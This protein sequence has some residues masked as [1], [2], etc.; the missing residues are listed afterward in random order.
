MIRTDGL[1]RMTARLVARRHALRKTI[2]EELEALGDNAQSNAGGDKLD[3]ALET[4][5]GEVRFQLLELEI[6]ELRKIEHVLRRLAEGSYGRCAR[7]GRKI[8]AARLNALPYAACC[9]RCQRDRDRDEI[10]R[11]PASD[12]AGWERISDWPAE[13]G[14]SDTPINQDNVKAEVGELCILPRSRFASAGSS[15]AGLGQP[16]T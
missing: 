12:S 1:L 14:K 2:G 11:L 8:A 5:N 4:A 7:C 3:A 6:Q 15:G 9:I 13:P 10:R 16:H